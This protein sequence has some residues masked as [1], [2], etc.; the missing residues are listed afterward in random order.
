MPIK[1]KHVSKQIPK[2]VQY[3]DTFQTPNYATAWIDDICL[4]TTSKERVK[5]LDGHLVK[6][7]KPIGLLRR[8]FS[9]FVD[10]GDWILSPFMGTGTCGIVAQELGCNYIGIEIDKNIFNLAKERI[11]GCENS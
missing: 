2:Q 7:Q 11:K 4:T 1:P 6:W 10:K 8:I 9:P 5:G 3:K